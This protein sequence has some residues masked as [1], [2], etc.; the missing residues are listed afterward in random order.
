MQEL[1]KLMARVFGLSKSDISESCTVENTEGWDSFNH[2]V[3]LE[4]LEDTFS[5]SVTIEDAERMLSYFDIVDV[6]VKKGVQKDS[7]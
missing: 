5:I 7:I 1:K 4:E 3:L 6:L 2:L